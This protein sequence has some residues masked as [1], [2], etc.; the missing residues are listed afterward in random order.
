MKIMNKKLM[1]LMILDGFG[2]EKEKRGN[3]IK[4]ANTPNLN[5]LM[6]QKPNTIL[7]ASGKYVGLLDGIMGNSEVGHATI[8]SRQNYLPRPC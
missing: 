1:L 2:V 5:K 8:G 3:A 6:K 7:N 4:L